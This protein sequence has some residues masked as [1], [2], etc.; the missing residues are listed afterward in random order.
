MCK[1]ILYIFILLSLV[2]DA[3]EE[4]E[5]LQNGKDR[6]ITLHIR[7]TLPRMLLCY[8]IL[9]SVALSFAPATWTSMISWDLSSLHTTKAHNVLQDGVCVC[10]ACVCAVWGGSLVLN[11]SLVLTRRLFTSVWEGC[12]MFFFNYFLSGQ[13]GPTHWTFMSRTRTGKHLHYSARFFSFFIVFIHLSIQLHRSC[14]IGLL[15]MA[16][17]CSFQTPSVKLGF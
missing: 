11:Y 9:T 8:W 13:R 2:E 1:Y 12:W 4:E 17:L 3:G 16:F 5:R 7:T 10:L 14:F 15:L 6:G